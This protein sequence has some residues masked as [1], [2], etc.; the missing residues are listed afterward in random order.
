MTLPLD[1][2]SFIL[3]IT[4]AM[5][6]GLSKTGIPGIGILPIVMVAFIW[7]SPKESVGIILPILIFCDLFAV[8][9][10]YRNVEWKMLLRLFPSVA[11]GM[12]PAWWLLGALPDRPF[13]I[14]LGILILILLG[15]EWLRRHF[16]MDQVPQQLWFTTLMGFLAGFSSTIANAGG[17]VMTIY[18]LSFRM[19]KERF[20]GTCAWFFFLLNVS[21]LLPTCNQGIITLSTL[22]VN[23]WMIPTALV[24][25]FVGIWLLPWIPQRR[26]EQIASALTAV[27]AAMLLVR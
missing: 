7:E 27:A 1:V 9:K 8:T 5:L 24:G 11:I 17:P 18:L 6:I 25:I 20:V 12:L 2:P 22:S 4:A 3:L 10:Y 21:K 23:L 26:F 15:L 14:G 16:A 19:P 13:K